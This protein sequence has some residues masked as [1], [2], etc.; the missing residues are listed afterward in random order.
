M[1]TR[2]F[3]AQQLERFKGLQRQVY[4]TLQQVADTLQPGVTE[5][6]VARRIH[7][8]LKSQGARTYFH[9]PVAL[10]GDRSAYPGAFG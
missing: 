9:V 3:T 6:A 4:T 10:F 2:D 8:A 5:R 1:Q 7:A